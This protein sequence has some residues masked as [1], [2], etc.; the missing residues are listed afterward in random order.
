MSSFGPYFLLRL[1]ALGRHHASKGTG[2]MISMKGGKAENSND[3]E[4][5]KINITSGRGSFSKPNACLPSEDT[6]EMR[7]FPCLAPL[8]NV[9]APP[10][11]VFRG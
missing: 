11:L 3:M 6:I 4:Y 5:I 2:G 7:G 1:M 9:G 10:T 8:C